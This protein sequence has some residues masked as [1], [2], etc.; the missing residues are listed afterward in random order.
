MLA[1]MNNDLPNCGEIT[2]AMLGRRWRKSF[3]LPRY[4][5]SFWWE[6]D[7]FEITKA[8]RFVEYE[9]KTSR[10]DFSADAKKG[11][12]IYG[13]FD[14]ESREPVRR[15]KHEMIVAGEGPSRFW[16]VATLGLIR[17]I[18]EWAGLIEI[19]RSSSNL[20]RLKERVIKKAPR[21]H[22]R[23]ICDSVVKHAKATCYYR[24]HNERICNYRSKKG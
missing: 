1:T 10:G 9:I 12:T 18:P 11:R 23:R 2:H 13:L 17:D 8:G 20:F 14:I 16:F 4:T 22:S 7:I 21:I 6:C 24:F 19:C 15:T 5:P 3:V